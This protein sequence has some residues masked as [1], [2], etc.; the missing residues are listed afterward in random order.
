MRVYIRLGEAFKNHQFHMCN[1]ME[2]TTSHLSVLTNHGTAAGCAGIGPSAALTPQESCSIT[3]R[4]GFK[5]LRGKKTCCTEGKESPP[6][7]KPYPW[8]SSP[9]A[10]LQAMQNR[11]QSHQ[12]QPQVF[13]QL[14]TAKV[15][16]FSSKQPQSPLLQPTVQGEAHSTAQI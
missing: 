13:I 7:S 9:S 3:K 14:L 15:K 1:P 10:S 16:T 5:F 12:R 8:F 6:V 2:A 11:T 4:A